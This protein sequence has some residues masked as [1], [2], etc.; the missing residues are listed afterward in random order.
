MLFFFRSSKSAVHKTKNEEIFS[1]V[2]RPTDFEIIKCDSKKRKNF[3][4]FFSLDITKRIKT[5]VFEKGEKNRVTQ[6]NGP[7]PLTLFYD[8]VAR[9]KMMFRSKETDFHVA[10]KRVLLNCL[11]EKIFKFSKRWRVNFSS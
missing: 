9:L 4:V 8:R 5:Q 3:T 6:K 7:N 11:R 10:Q 2:K 1:P